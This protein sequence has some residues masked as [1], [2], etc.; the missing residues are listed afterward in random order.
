MIRTSSSIAIASIAFLLS[1]I[2]TVA[3]AGSFRV[4]PVRVELT[5]TQPSVALTVRNESEKDDVVVQ[6]RATDWKQVN[7][8]D[9][10]T[11]STELIASPPIFTIKAGSTQTVRVGLRKAELRDLQQTF[12]LYITEVPPPPREGFQGLQVALNIGIPV[13]VAPRTR[14]TAPE[15]WRASVL[16]NGKLNVTVANPA[17]AHSQI[18]EFSI[19]DEK[20]GVAIALSQQPRYILAGKEVVWQLPITR[21]PV[22]KMRVTA[23]TDRGTLEALVSP[24]AAR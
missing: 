14:T 23:K 17:N 11:P 24:A 1:S 2:S 6:L 5:P 19:F 13:F 3:D 18:L 8:E 9:V 21:T 15:E 16:E 20:D 22:G 10:Y 4:S 7:G 12:R